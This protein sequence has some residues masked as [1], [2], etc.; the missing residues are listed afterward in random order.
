MMRIWMWANTLVILSVLGVVFVNPR[1][2]GL[3]FLG[4]GISTGTRLLFHTSRENK[5]KK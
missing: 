5:G 4:A 2:A 1:L 3:I